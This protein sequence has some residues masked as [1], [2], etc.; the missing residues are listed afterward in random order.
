[1]SPLLGTFSTLYEDLRLELEC[2]LVLVLHVLLV[3]LYARGINTTFP[4][5]KSRMWCTLFHASAETFTLEKLA[6]NLE[7]VSENIDTRHLPPFEL[8]RP[9]SQITMASRFLGVKRIPDCD[10][11]WNQQ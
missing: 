11:C 7:I 8:I 2:R 9:V 10:F 4:S 5:Y 3:P 6:G 1:V